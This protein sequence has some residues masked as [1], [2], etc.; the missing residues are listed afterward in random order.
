[1]SGGKACNQKITQPNRKFRTRIT[2]PASGQKNASVENR[3]EEG[4]YPL[5]SVPLMKCHTPCWGVRYLLK[6]SRGFKLI[7]ESVTLS[8]CGVVEVVYCCFKNC[9]LKSLFAII[10][11]K[12]S[13]I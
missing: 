10:K 9:Y 13:I 11:E 1:M 3:W 4:L 7:H 8:T 5:K 2:I 6:N 12:G